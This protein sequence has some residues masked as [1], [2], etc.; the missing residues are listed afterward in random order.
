MKFCTHCGNELLNEA[1]FCPK[2]GR[3][4]DVLPVVKAEESVTQHRYC[5]YCGNQVL[6]QAVVCTKCGCAIKPMPKTVSIKNGKGLQIATKVLMILSCVASG[7]CAIVMAG[8]ALMFNNM[9]IIDDYYSVFAPMY[10]IFSIICLVPLCWT[11]PMTKH[12]INAIKQGRPV[13]IAFKVCTLIFVNMIAG[14]L[15]LCDTSTN[16]NQNN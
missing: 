4:C 16:I 2:C 14:V 3:S 11:F 8:I 10:L 12:Y 9:S 6:K 15:M 13:G 7:I 5:T 1:V